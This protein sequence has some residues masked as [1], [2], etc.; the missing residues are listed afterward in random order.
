MPAGHAAAVHHRTVLW[1]AVA[2]LGAS[3]LLVD[4]GDG[5]LRLP[6]AGTSLPPTCAFRQTFGVDCPGCG[7]TR[8][9]VA[10][11]HGRLLAAWHY[12]P[13][14]TLLFAILTA[15]VPY[16]LWQLRRLARGQP[17]WN[18]RLLWPAA[19]VLIAMLFIQWGLKISGI[20]RF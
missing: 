2:A 20:I 12:H 18:H 4:S 16:R 14:G 15:Q 6:F 17:E 11:A 7:L 13:L 10:L 5:L 19:S 9:F 1:L 3:V 8:C